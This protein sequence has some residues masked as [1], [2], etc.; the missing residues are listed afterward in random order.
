MHTKSE[1]RKPIQDFIIHVKN[2]FEKTIKCFR[3]DN[4]P[5]FNCVDIYNAYGINHQR[6]FVET[7]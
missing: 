5:E 2:Q 3:T 7:P 6:S 1:T 4:G